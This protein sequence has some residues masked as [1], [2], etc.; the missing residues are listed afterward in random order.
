MRWGFLSLVLIFP[1]NYVQLSHLY[2]LGYCSDIWA[3]TPPATTTI[4]GLY[5]WHVCG[6]EL[7][8]L[9][10]VAGVKACDGCC[11]QWHMF[12]YQNSIPGITGS[13]VAG[14]L[15]AYE[16]QALTI[17]VLIK[18]GAPL[19]PVTPLLSSGSG[20]RVLIPHSRSFF[21]RILCPALLVDSLL[22]L[23]RLFG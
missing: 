22:P 1:P 7:I 23:E 6:V 11:C 15:A 17:T 18:P 14:S 3:N 10:R 4:T 19:P 13:Y 5:H 9:C 16:N 2:C 21:V 12:S 20:R 8:Q